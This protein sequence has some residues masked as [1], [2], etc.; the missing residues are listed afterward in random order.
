MNHE[1]EPHE[2]QTPEDDALDS[3]LYPYGFVLPAFFTEQGVDEGGS[4]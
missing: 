2:I 1:D 4:D 3:W